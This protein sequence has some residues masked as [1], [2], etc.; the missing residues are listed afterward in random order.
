MKTMID[1]RPARDLARGLVCALLLIAFPAA[2]QV[3]P[4][5]PEP[6]ADAQAAPAATAAPADGDAASS[7][8]NVAGNAA[9]GTTLEELLASVNGEPLVAERCIRSSAIDTT[10]VLNPRLVVFKVGRRTIYINQMPV[11]CPGLKPKAKIAL[12]ARDDRLCQLDSIRVLHPSGM[13]SDGSDN[14]MFGPNCMLGKFERITEEQLG[15]LEE[16]FT[17]RG[18]NLLDVLFE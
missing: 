7:A 2:A 10:E 17:P 5:A 9:E 12:T 14:I 4:A 15:V 13:A 16:R 6:A 3:A 8:G 18:R 1:R 11:D